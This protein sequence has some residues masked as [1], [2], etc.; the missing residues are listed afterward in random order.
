MLQ[1][2]PDL[3]L[4]IFAISHLLQEAEDTENLFCPRPTQGVITITQYG[5]QASLAEGPELKFTIGNFN[6]LVCVCELEYGSSVGSR[7]IFNF[8][9][10]NMID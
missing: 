5:R 10:Q 7:N 2:W 8:H 3:D 4:F 1:P 6:F 9:W